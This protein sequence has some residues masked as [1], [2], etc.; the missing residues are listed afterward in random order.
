MM[1]SNLTDVLQRS[2]FCDADKLENRVRFRVPTRG[3]EK[4][5]IGMSGHINRRLV[6]GGAAPKVIGDTL[7]R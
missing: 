6:D 3:G 5:R 2:E 1:Q 7:S 4:E